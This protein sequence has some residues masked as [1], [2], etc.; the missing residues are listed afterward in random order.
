MRERLW[1]LLVLA[2]YRAER[3]ADAL[4][5]YRR[6]RAV[7]AEELGIE[8]GEE[9]RQLE[10]AVLRQEVPPPVT[11]AVTRALPRDVAS[12][13]GRGAELRRLLGD[14]VSAAAGGGWWRFVRSAGWPGSAR[15][16]WRCT[17][18][19]GSRSG[20]RTGSYSCRCTRTPRGSGRWIPPMR[21]PA[22]CWRPGSVP[23][24]CPRRRSCAASR[25]QGGFRTARAAST[26]AHFGEAFLVRSPAV[27]AVSP[28]DRGRWGGDTS[29][30]WTSGA[31]WP[32]S[33]PPRSSGDTAAAHRAA[34]SSPCRYRRAR[35]PR[36]R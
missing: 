6:A 4:A 21:W 35:S 31:R 29:S 10:E 19:T 18:R 34:G 27:R 22:C 8:P 1:R 24:R 33:R 12:F 14:A 28:L 36:Q 20:S 30:S 9:L 26:G 32:G 13:T 23:G 11:A 17:R 5:A 7:L 3:Q 16:R 2:L 15:P 25:A